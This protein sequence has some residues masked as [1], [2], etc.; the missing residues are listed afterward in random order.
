MK[1][2]PYH[3]SEQDGKDVG[4]AAEAVTGVIVWHESGPSVLE[5]LEWRLIRLC[6]A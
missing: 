2:R 4:A 6:D 3:I 5:D 1:R